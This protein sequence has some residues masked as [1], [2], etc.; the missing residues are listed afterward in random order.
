MVAARLLSSFRSTDPDVIAA[1]GV[2]ANDPDA[3]PSLQ[4]AAAMALR[5]VHTRETL[6]YLA[7]LLDTPDLARQIDG[8]FG[9]SGFANGFDIQTPGNTASMGWLNNSRPTA[10]TTVETMDHLLLSFTTDSVKRDEM[11]S[12]WKA[13]WVLNRQQLGY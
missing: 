4:A 10:Y 1:L 2:V 5:A 8:V 7:L 13:W 9:L 11:V 12:F 3:H 6:P